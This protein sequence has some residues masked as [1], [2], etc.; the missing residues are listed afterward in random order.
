[1]LEAKD[2]VLISGVVVTLLLGV[3]N[4]F[5]NFVLNRRTSFINTVTSERVKWIGKLR[6]N[7]STF[8]GLTH[9]WFVSKHDVDQQ[10]VEDILRELRVLRY[11]I[12]LQLNPKPDAVIDKKIMQLVRDIPDSAAKPETSVLLASLDELISE[13]QQLLKAEWDKVKRE[14][15]RGML[16][17]TPLNKRRWFNNLNAIGLVLGMAGVVLIFIWGPPQPSFEQGVAII[18]ESGNVLPD[19]KTVAQHD[20]EATTNKQQYKLISQIGLAFIFMGFV[21]QFVETVR[22]DT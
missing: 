3:G 2:I 6:E 4:L 18:L 13:G 20:K 19:G 12:T 5:Y 9:Y 7:I 15:Q 8:V 14:S 21:C 17:D 22:T 11:H 1:M 16:A 10:K